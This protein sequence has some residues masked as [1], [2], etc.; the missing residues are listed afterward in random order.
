MTDFPNLGRQVYRK[1]LKMDPRQQLAGMTPHKDGSVV[2][3]SRWDV[4]FRAFR[5]R[6][7][8]GYRW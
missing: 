3:T 4:F 5:I 8:Q 7:R 6:R 1:I 2:E